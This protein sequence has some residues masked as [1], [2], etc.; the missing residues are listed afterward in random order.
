[1]VKSCGTLHILF[2][3]PNSPPYN[4]RFFNE[5]YCNN[6]MCNLYCTVAYLYDRSSFLD[7][8]ILNTYRCAEYLGGR[9]TQTNWTVL[10]VNPTVTTFNPIN[11]IPHV[12][13]C[14]ECRWWSDPFDT[15]HVKFCR[16]ASF[17]MTKLAALARQRTVDCHRR[18]KRR[19]EY[20]NDL[21]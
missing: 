6:A 19:I 10:T 16:L 21:L 9:N 15:P 2:Y 4:F 7:L 11:R 20:P 18:I 13:E 3:M 12:D 5:P 1:M 14:A 17:E 8:L